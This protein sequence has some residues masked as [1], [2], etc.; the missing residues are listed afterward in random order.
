MK[1]KAVVFDVDGTLYA[2][3]DMY[4]RS[5][6]FAIKHLGF[7]RAFSRVRK[8]IR[9][10]PEI[11]DFLGTQASLLGREL[12]K[13]TEEAAEIIKKN[14]SE[15]EDGLAGIPFIRGLHEFLSHLE[16]AGI[17]KGL[18]S[19][20][21]IDRKLQVIGLD[22]KW[23]CLISSEETGFLKPH[24]RP[25]DTVCEKLQL[26]PESILYVGNSYRYD[27]IGASSVGMHTAHIAKK[28]PKDSVADITVAN[29]YQLDSWLFTRL[30]E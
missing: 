13:S 27:V 11:E 19:D 17:R 4:R 30:T 12:K 28:A 3:A 5:T 14:V 21:P 2:N 16:K 10:L 15:W 26:E 29:Y 22:I 25:F 6:L 18:L 23:D 7:V 1:V 24:R 9:Q 8:Q 20:F